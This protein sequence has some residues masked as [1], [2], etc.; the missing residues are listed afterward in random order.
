MSKSR[1]VLKPA[2]VGGGASSDLTRYIAKSKLDR[3]REGD[4]DR[5]LFTEERDDLTFWEARKWLSVTGGALPREDALH[6]VLSFERPQEYENLGKDDRDRAAAV[7]DYLRRSLSQAARE[8]G[9]GD[10]RWAA[11]IHLN[12][13][14][15]HVHILI[16]KNV[17]DR[18]TGELRRIEKLPQPL[19]AH[20]K[21]QDGNRREFDYGA[22]INS[23]AESVDARLRAR[24]Q[25]RAHNERGGRQLNEKPARRTHLGDRI[26]L[27]ESMW[28]RHTVEQLERETEALKM[29]GDKRRFRLFDPTH[30][31]VRHV[32]AHDIRRRAEAE[33]HRSISGVKSPSPA[34]REEARRQF[35]DAHL[36]RHEEALAEHEEKVRERLVRLETRLDQARTNHELLRPHVEDLR[37]RYKEKG[38]PLPVPLLSSEQVGKLQDAAIEARDAARIRALEKIR[39]A[40]AAE[41]GTPPRDLHERGRIIAQLREAE[42]DFAARAWRERQFEQGFH[43]TRWEVGGERFSLAGVDARLE[44]ERVK[45]SFVHVG[46]SAL[47]PSWKREAQ[48]EMARLREVRRHVEEQIGA[49]QKELEGE[50]ERAA[51]TARALREISDG[52]AQSQGGREHQITSEIIAP[53]YT[54]AELDRMESHAHETRDARLL[55]EVHEA[56]REKNARLA[57]EKR[58]P[59]RKLAA[60]AEARTFVAELDFRKAR[61]ARAEQAKWGRF[62]PVAARLADGSIIT[63]SVRQTEVLS[64]ADAIIRMVED[65]PER[66]GRAGAITRAAA[67]REAQSQG[68]YDAAAAYLAAARMIADEYRQEL[69]EVGKSAPRPE[70]S[71]KD[72]NR[73]DL[74]R[75]QSDRPDERRALQQLLDRSEAAFAPTRAGHE[76]E[77][78]PAGD[79]RFHAEREQKQHT[80]EPHVRSR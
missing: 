7:R 19:V 67:R 16:N 36:A 54:R 38:E 27:G 53:I 57:P 47:V 5:P 15:P 14:H 12:K 46:V 48:D 65:S 3:R 50:R 63:G 74:H 78:P 55:M 13:P 4:R 72:L 41:G 79:N 45:T 61:D 18:R 59:M 66:R 24:T 80:P 8:I 10:W 70:F 21:V 58:T 69:E 26:L 31:R 76:R 64:R 9:V 33:A 34:A 60:E 42:T 11:G 43:L 39:Q 6:Y 71:P 77:S 56:R 75:A 32:S 49:R 17:I 29:Y 52:E 62:T 1:F 40:L 20:N 37:E 23:F 25:E 2:H 51:G 35:L 73:I 44:K 22:I 28:S 68:A 30:G